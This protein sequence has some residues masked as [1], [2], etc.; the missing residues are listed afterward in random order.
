[1]TPK[2][3]ALIAWATRAA[4]ELAD[5]LDLPED[6]QPA[7]PVKRGHGRRTPVRPVVTETQMAEGRRLARMMGLEVVGGDDEKKAG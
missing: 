6:G 3:A 7:R 2:R 5:I 4:N 1:M